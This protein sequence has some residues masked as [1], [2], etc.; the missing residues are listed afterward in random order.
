MK[1]S[2]FF[3]WEEATVSQEATRRGIDNSVPTS[4][5]ANVERMAYL[6]DDIRLKV[7]RPIIVSSWYRCPALNK[8]IRGSKSSAH[9]KGL[10]VDCICPDLGSPLKFAETIAALMLVEPYDQL[11]AEAG[12]WVHIGLTDGDPRQQLLTMKVE[13]LAFGRTRQVYLNGLVA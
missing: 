8:A 3:T 2:T 12:R 10:A 9:M 5:R 4:L 13:K 11:I 7:E 1:L 6:M